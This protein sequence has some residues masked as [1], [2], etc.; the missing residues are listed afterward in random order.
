MKDKLDHLL[1]QARTASN[2]LE[3]DVDASLPPGLA[4]RIA[5]RWSTDDDHAQYA[6]LF[7]RVTAC[8]LLPVLA[9]WAVFA[10]SRPAQA[11]LNV[12]DL[13]YTAQLIVEA[14]PPF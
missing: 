12:M 14:P 8:C 11:E 4:T 13:L 7:E 3:T 10:W 9:V 5:A 1:Q 2:G 6:A